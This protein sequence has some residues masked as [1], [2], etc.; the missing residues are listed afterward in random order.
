MNCA[1]L[2]N[3]R[4]IEKRDPSKLIRARGSGE[5]GTRN[6]ETPRCDLPVVTRKD[7]SVYRALEYGK[8][9]CDEGCQ[10]TGLIIYVLVVVDVYV[11]RGSPMLHFLVEYLE[12]LE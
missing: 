10:M 5:W 1:A 7:G 4:D 2:S 12:V 3:E 9:N 11:K 6:M 8:A